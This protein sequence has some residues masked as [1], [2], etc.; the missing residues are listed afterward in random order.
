MSENDNIRKEFKILKPIPKKFTI[1]SQKF[2]LIL[3]N[4]KAIFN[5]AEIDY[6]Y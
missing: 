6:I 5:K 1:D 3:N 4:Q 2:Q